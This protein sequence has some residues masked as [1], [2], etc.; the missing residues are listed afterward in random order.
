MR[1]SFPHSSG[2]KPE[3]FCRGYIEL[4]LINGQKVSGSTCWLWQR[5][6]ILRLFVFDT[7]R[8]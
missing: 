7:L 2:T 1:S 3:D 5:F 4:R 6:G 8:F